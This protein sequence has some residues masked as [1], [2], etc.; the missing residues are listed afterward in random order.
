MKIISL[1]FSDTQ[2]GTHE[3]GFITRSFREDA[4]DEDFRYQLHVLKHLAPGWHCRVVDGVLTVHSP[5][6]LG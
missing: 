6:D 4:D 3:Y 2:I 1:L 5:T